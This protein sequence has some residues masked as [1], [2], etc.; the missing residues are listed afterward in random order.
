MFIL[1]LCLGVISSCFCSREKQT[2]YDDMLNSLL[3]RDVSFVDSLLGLKGVENPQ[4]ILICSVYDCGTCLNSA[5]AELKL[6]GGRLD[7]LSIQVVGVLSD[8]TPL[9]TRFEYYDYIAYDIDDV[10]RRHLKYIPTPT[11]IVIDQNRQIRYLY[12]P[13]AEDNPESVA[14]LLLQNSQLSFTQ[15]EIL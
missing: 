12:R 7:S 11:F 14:K 4:V 13:T 2:R 3:G 10:I 1:S 8:P 15:H 6:L 9:Q 5:F